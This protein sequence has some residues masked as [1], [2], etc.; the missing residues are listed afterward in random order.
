[1]NHLIN[2]TFAD[3]PKRFWSVDLLTDFIGFINELKD[4]DEPEVHER[5]FELFNVKINQ[6]INEFLRD[7][8]DLKMIM[9][10]RTKCDDDS[11]FGGEE[12]ARFMSKIVDACSTYLKDSDFLE[13][14]N[15]GDL[16]YTI[17]KIK[18]KARKD[19][20]YAIEFEK[21]ARRLYLSE[22]IDK[23]EEIFKSA[24][25][26]DGNREF[27]NVRDFMDNKKFFESF[28]NS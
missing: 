12:C 21:S 14:D 5:A 16:G 3:S 20:G 19:R 11:H 23:T 9:N 8:N 17:R 10:C 4:Y 1:M 24:G 22:G 27:N 13:D 15:E 6:A 2:A 7:M 18:E 28:E 25:Y 26:M